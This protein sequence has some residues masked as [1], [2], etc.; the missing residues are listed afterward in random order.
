MDETVSKQLENDNTF[1]TAEN[2]TKKK[3]KKRI[4]YQGR[5]GAI[6]DKGQF[7]E[8]SSSSD[9]DNSGSSD[10]ESVGI[11]PVKDLPIGSSLFDL[12]RTER[13]KETLAWRKSVRAKKKMQKLRR[14][15]ID[16]IAL[17]SGPLPNLIPPGYVQSP[18]VPVELIPANLLKRKILYRWE[19][20]DVKAQGWFIGTICAP[21]K[22]EGFN[23][24]IKYD[25]FVTLNHYVDGIHK[26]YLSHAGNNA[27]G[28]RWVL[29]DRTDGVVKEETET[30]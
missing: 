20:D 13:R 28:R 6:S 22:S 29:L 5:R 10:D 7:V 2:S 19:G 21:S 24:N 16:T 8:S 27:Y 3:K 30:N 4:I 23:F 11:H 15:E 12:D 25:K 14:G 1:T 26:V 18:N 9:E 17:N